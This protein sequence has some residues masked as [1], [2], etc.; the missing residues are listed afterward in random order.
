VNGYENHHGASVAR[1]RCAMIG[2]AASV[3]TTFTFLLAVILLFKSTDLE[4]RSA[5]L[6]AKPR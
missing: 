1:M 6:P 2:V 4:I 3:A 5:W